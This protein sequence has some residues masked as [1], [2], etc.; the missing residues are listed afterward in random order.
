M[1]S[2]EDLIRMRLEGRIPHPLYVDL[3][4]DNLPSDDHLRI[5]QHESLHSIDFRG[6]QG[7]VVS[8]SGCDAKRVKAVAHACE[9]A[10]ARR[11]IANTSQKIDGPAMFEVI[12][13]TDTEGIF[14]WKK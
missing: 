10:G 11:V 4:I 9:E 3:D 5:H 14:T 8:V 2:A 13:V 6:V 1:R 7:L 12:E